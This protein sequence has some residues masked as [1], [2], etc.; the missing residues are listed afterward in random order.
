MALPAT[1][2]PGAREALSRSRPGTQ[3][4]SPA[5]ACNSIRTRRVTDT[6]S[7]NTDPAWPKPARDL[8]HPLFLAEAGAQLVQAV[9]FAMWLRPGGLV[10]TPGLAVQ[11]EA[12]W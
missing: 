11:L 2:S 9:L 10:A 5:F 7:A 12:G 4:P 6:S 3:A 1:P 8:P